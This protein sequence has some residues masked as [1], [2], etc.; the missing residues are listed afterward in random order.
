[1]KKIFITTFS[2]LTVLSLQAQVAVNNELKSLIGQSFGYFPKVKEIQNTVTTAQEKVALTELNKFPDIT[3]DASYTYVQ[4]KITLPINGETFQFAPVHNFSGAVNANY[5][6]F[7][8]GR[9]QANVNRSKE[10]LQY[11]K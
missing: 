5:A 6:L 1:M 10:D 4:P 7:D 8:F 9:L 11:A 3:A 2:I